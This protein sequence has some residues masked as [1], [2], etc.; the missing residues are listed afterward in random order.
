MIGF[1][2]SQ[3]QAFAKYLLEQAAP[4][5]KVLIQHCLLR[6]VPYCRFGLKKAS[7]V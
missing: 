6:R 1:A 5:Y 7:L 2:E 4:K 3:A